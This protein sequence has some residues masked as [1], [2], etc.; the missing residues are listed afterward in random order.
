MESVLRQVF[1]QD[2]QTSVA[3]CYVYQR[4]GFGF[5][6]MLTKK[7]ASIAF[8]ELQ[9]AAVSIPGYPDYKLEIWPSWTTPHLRGPCLCWMEFGITHAALGAV[10]GGVFGPRC[11]ADLLSGMLVTGRGGTLKDSAANYILVEN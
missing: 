7:D 3:S 10:A 11:R 1:K 6:N 9:G 8:E 2:G 5:V 4:R